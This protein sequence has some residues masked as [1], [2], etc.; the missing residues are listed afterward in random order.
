MTTETTYDPKDTFEID[1]AAQRDVGQP[2]HQV[3]LLSA[4]GLDVEETREE[5]F[6]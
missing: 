6:Q 4:L 5:Q 2:D 3:I 1:N